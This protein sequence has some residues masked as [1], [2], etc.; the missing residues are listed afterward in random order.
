VIEKCAKIKA[1]IVEK[2]EKERKSRKI[3]NYGHTIGHAIETGE[4]YNIT[5][6]EAIGMGMIY[7]GKISEKIGL[8]DKKSLERQNRLIR[9]VGLPTK[10]KGKKDLIK[11]MKKDKKNKN[12][13]IYFILLESIGKAKHENGRYAFPIDE[14]I[15][16][17]CLDE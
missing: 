5:H 11:I 1:G 17:E 13:R 14:S 8:L 10:Y 6:G 9:A 15:V 7:E 2:D 16:R 4:N 3:L 12:G